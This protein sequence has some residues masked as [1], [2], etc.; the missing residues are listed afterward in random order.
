MNMSN[1]CPICQV[2]KADHTLARGKLQ[3]TNIP[4][5]KWSEV[6]LDF[7]TD[8]PTTR[9]KKDSILTVVD[10]ATRMV[11]LIPCKKSITAAETAKIFWDNI[12]KLHG[13]PAVLYSDRGTQFTSDFWKSLWDLTGTQLRFSTAYHPQTQGV[14]E[15]MNSVVGQMLR[16]IIH[17][18][19]DSSWDSLLPTVEMTINSL[20]NS[21][22]GY[23]PFFLNYGYHPVLPVELLKGDEEVKT[24]AVDNFVKRIQREWDHAKRNLLQSVQ[25]QQQYYNQRHRMV[26]YKVGDLLLLSSKNLSFKNIPAKLQKKFVGPFEVIEKIGPQ[27]YRLDLPDTWKIHNVFHVSLLKRWKTSVYRETEDETAAELN[28]EEK[29][30]DVIEKILRWKKT[31]R[32]QPPAYLI[33]WK[34]H[35]LEEATWEPASRFKTEE[36]QQLLLRDEPEEIDD[37]RGR[38]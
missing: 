8:L 34:G 24:E 13:I 27:A 17:E 20:P 9:N 5:K 18:N 33:L 35:P 21:S 16:C 26:E 11:H 23:S 15:R 2:E 3:S 29:K 25:K 10:K 7:I 19:R 14:V 1:S 36:F 37:E 4:E 31:G 22:T 32:G 38:S 30:T 28:I 6:S 12:V